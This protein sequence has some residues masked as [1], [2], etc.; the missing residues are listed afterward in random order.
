MVKKIRKIRKQKPGYKTT[1][2][3]MT[4]LM[5]VGTW[6]TSLK[7]ILPAKQAAIT[8]GIAVSAYAIA[9]GLQKSCIQEEINKIEKDE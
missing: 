3:W 7:D 8:S 5:V 6:A 9:R 1:E 4:V 2:F